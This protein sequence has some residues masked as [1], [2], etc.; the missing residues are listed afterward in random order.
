M[1]AWEL[2]RA[3]SAVPANTPVLVHDE[4][5]ALAPVKVMLWI[6]DTEPKLNDVGLME[7]RVISERVELS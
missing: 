5:G 7:P 1:T 2:I 6:R 4:D 3:L